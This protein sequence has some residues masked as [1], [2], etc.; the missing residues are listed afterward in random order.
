[1]KLHGGANLPTCAER[2]VQDSIS[3]DD[4]SKQGSLNFNSKNKRDSS[5]EEEELRGNREV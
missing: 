1:M 5:E 2:E 3:T 4:T